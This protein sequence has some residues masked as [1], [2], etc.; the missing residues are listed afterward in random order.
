MSSDSSDHTP[1]KTPIDVAV[2]GLVI[3]PDVF[4]APSKGTN[5]DSSAAV[6]KAHAAAAREKPD[7]AVS[8]SSNGIP[9]W[10]YLPLIGVGIAAGSFV[11]PGNLSLSANVKGYDY[12][13]KYPEGVE[14]VGPVLDEYDPKVWVAKGK[15]QYGTVC[16]S[17]HQATGEGVAGQF[18]PLKNS[19]YVIHGEK[20]VAA[21]LL[22]GIIG[23]LQVNG[24]GYNGAMPAQGAVKT[25]KDIAQIV[26]YVRN[27]WGNKGSL[28]YDDQVAELRKSLASRT[29]PWNEA[30]LKAIP[31]DENLPPSKHSAPPDAA[32]TTPAAGAPVS[33]ATS[34]AAPPAK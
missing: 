22:H 11:D 33:P 5:S 2:E 29:V 24:K 21:I 28:V 20:R 23:P 34:P 16:A 9:L 19:E 17:C 31:Q 26:S 14:G 7:F 15:S 1:A 8:T 32:V 25:N 12:A 6:A 10:A 27:E 3:R 4:N 18:P 13:L 30:E